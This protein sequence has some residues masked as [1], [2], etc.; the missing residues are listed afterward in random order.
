MYRTVLVCIGVTCIYHSSFFLCCLTGCITLYAAYIAPV[1]QCFFG[2]FFTAETLWVFHRCVQRAVCRVDCFVISFADT[3][4]NRF[5]FAVFDVLFVVH[6]RLCFAIIHR[7]AFCTA[8][9]CPC[10]RCAGHCCNITAAFIMCVGARLFF[11]CRGISAVFSM[12]HC[13]VFIG[14]CTFAQHFVYCC[15]KTAA[16]IMLMCTRNLIHSCNISTFFAMNMVCAHCGACFLCV[17]RYRLQRENC[18]N[19]SHSCYKTDCSFHQFFGF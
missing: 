16:F 13:T 17:S 19:H 11:S 1:V 9:G 12:Q 6:C 4:H 15:S 8:F 18:D 10:A 7:I 14:F 5:S 3:F 2:T